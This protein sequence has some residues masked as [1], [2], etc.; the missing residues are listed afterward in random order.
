MLSFACFALLSYARLSSATQSFACFALLRFT[1]LGSARQC[2]TGLGYAC[3]AQLLRTSLCCTKLDYARQRCATLCFAC[4]ALLH[5]DYASLR[6]T[7]LRNAL[8]C[9]LR[10]AVLCFAVLRGTL[11]S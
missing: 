1:Q 4:F 2:M 5:S 7:M 3:F 10:F 9:L 11:Q 8:L 6:S